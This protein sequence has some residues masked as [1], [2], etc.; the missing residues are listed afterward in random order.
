MDCPGTTIVGDNGSVF[1]DPESGV[2]PL[3]TI[4]YHTTHET[5]AT[6]E[7][8]PAELPYTGIPAVEGLLLAFLLVVS[9]VGLLTR[10]ATNR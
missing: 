8:Q 7:S 6:V 4:T 10:Q 3:P 1:C 9:G 5:T 2:T